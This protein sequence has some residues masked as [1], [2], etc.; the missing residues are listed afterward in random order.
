MAVFQKK[1]IP[2]REKRLNTISAY[3]GSAADLLREFDGPEGAQQRIRTFS[4]THDDDV[5]Q[6]LQRF[7]ALPD[8]GLV[9]HGP[10]GCTAA[11]L[12]GSNHHPWVVSNL[13]ERDTIMGGEESLRDAIVALH[14]R[15]HPSLILVITTPVVAINNDDVA[16][17]TLEL[18][19]ELAAH[20]VP[21]YTDGFRSQAAIGGSDTV[22]YALLKQLPPA[23]KQAAANTVQVLAL[24]EQPADLAETRRLLALLGI[25]A[26]IVPQE[27]GWAG[28][29]VAAG[30]VAIALNRDETDF[31]GQ[32]LQ[33][34]WQTKFLPSAPPIGI[35]G[36]Y[37]WLAAL[38]EA[39][40]VSD[41]VEALHRVETATLQP[42]VNNSSLRHKTVYLS[43]PP[44]IAWR[45]AELVEELGGRLAGLTV[46]HV[47]ELH[48]QEL[49]ALAARRPDLPVQVGAGQVFEEVNLLRRHAPELYIGRADGAQWAARLGVA[50]VALERTPLLGY[51]G[52]VTL[53]R[54]ARKALA[55]PAFV[56]TLGTYC[57]TAYKDGWY[58][59]KANWHIKLEVK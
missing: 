45:T 10:R 59:K 28:L 47:D 39:L 23:H 8:T 4:E 38:G 57:G 3:H 14:T 27:K 22:L 17:V 15:H 41:A 46:D 5:L 21:V 7:S 42:V 37:R 51:Q 11:L 36:T 25:P 40:G 32:A 52:A 1:S 12:N 20:I 55:N 43:L 24:D 54:Q 29:E 18:S 50:A 33:E 13:A 16:A 58:Q 31:L 35:N 9:I 2:I 34:V 48:R 19:E 6:V 53:E 26:A 49:A 44:A 56:R 30:A